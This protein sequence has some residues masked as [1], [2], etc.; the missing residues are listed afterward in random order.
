MR[1][2]CRDL[3][4]LTH[5]C[6]LS[7]TTPVVICFVTTTEHGQYNYRDEP[8]RILNRY[9]QNIVFVSC[10]LKR[11]SGFHYPDFITYLLLC[12][13]CHGYVDLIKLFPLFL[14]YLLPF[15]RRSGSVNLNNCFQISDIKRLS[16]FPHLLTTFSK[17]FRLSKPKHWFTDISLRLTTDVEWNC[18]PPVYFRSRDICDPYVTDYRMFQGSSNSL[19]PW[20]GLVVNSEAENSVRWSPLW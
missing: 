1:S 19:H 9:A 2:N 15:R 10:S 8:R 11:F 7:Y 12:G 4:V 18:I 5:A 20:D 14:T 3:E 17:D 16:G 13:E 6:S